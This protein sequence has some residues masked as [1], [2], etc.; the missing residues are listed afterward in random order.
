MA[1]GYTVVGWNRQKRW[2]DGVVLGGVA[3]GVGAFVLVTAVTN[4]GMTAET[5]IIRA[6]A[7]A[8]LL[9]LHVILCIGP[10]ARLDERF[11]PLLYNR[12]HLGVAMFLMALVHGAF[13][14]LQFHGFGDANPLHSVFAAYARDYTLVSG[15]G[16]I[17]FE[18][19]GALALLILFLMA[20]TSHDF[21]LKNLGSPVWKALHQ[22]VYVAYGL[23]MLHVFFGALQSEASGA[24]VPVLAVGFAAIAGLHGA[25]WWQESRTDRARGDVTS[26]GFVD[27]A[28]AGELQEGCGRVVVAAGTR[29]ALYR[30]EGRAFAMS[31]VCRHQGGPLGEG[32]IVDGCATCPWH[33]WNYRPQ[34][35]LSPPPFKEIVST[36]PVRVLNG[37]VQ[38][39]PEPFPEGTR[40]EGAHLE[41]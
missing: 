18:A 37:R 26:D 23:I 8:A 5:I 31:N 15:L 29:I 2:Y 28:A 41:S 11:A 27:V 4:P 33:G 21:W 13:S 24:L 1:H 30:H 22:L 35:G 20:A 12:R 3:L 17:P 38:V 9:L 32:R 39:R 16:Q 7:L 34:D 10:L 25:S 6:S 14:V 40:S 19:F 36:Y